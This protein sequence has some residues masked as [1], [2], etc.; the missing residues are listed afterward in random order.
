MGWKNR[1]DILRV[2]FAFLDDGVVDGEDGNK[3]KDFWRTLRRK[4]DEKRV[5][6]MKKEEEKGRRVR[7]F[8]KRF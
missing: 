4:K 1:V 7:M 8:K 2:F 5:R 3:C 6:K